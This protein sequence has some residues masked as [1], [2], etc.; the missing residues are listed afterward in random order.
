MFSNK[1][2][3]CLACT[4]TVAFLLSIAAVQLVQARTEDELPPAVVENEQPT[5]DTPTLIMTLDGNATAPEDQSE[6]PNL[7]QSQD[8]PTAVDDNSTGLID[9]DDTQGNQENS[10]IST[11]TS[12][13]YTILIVGIAGLIAVTA[14]IGAFLFVR[15][16]NKTN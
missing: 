9:Q 11:Q 3:R 7:Y 8:S 2:K 4:L 1:Q 15:R 6:Q 12:P 13:D 14:A 10:L 16:Q 5:A